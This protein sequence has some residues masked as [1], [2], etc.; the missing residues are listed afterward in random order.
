MCDL[1]LQRSFCLM[2]PKVGVI[3]KYD[4]KLNIN[5]S[6]CIECRKGAGIYD[7]KNRIIFLYIMALA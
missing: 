6:F 5:Q 1:K 2:Q 4:R 3:L 7:K